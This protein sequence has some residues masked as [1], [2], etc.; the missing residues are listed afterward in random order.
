[1][2][3]VESGKRA[4]FLPWMAPHMAVAP[5]G[6]LLACE[7]ASQHSFLLLDPRDFRVLAQCPGHGGGKVTVPAFSPDARRLATCGAD[8]SNV[9][10]WDTSAF[11]PSAPPGS[12]PQPPKAPAES[13]A[14]PQAA[15]QATAH[16]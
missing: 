6:Q 8:D 4:G 11:V 14:A 13:A 2:W 9:K 10:L 1:V 3:D 16:D 15:S 7:D 12:P 5:G